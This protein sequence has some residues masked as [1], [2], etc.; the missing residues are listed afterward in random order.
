MSDRH[1]IITAHHQDEA[2][3]LR[4]LLAQVALPPAG[5]QDRA[6]QLIQ[7]ARNRP[8]A[9]FD[10]FLQEFSLSNAEGVSLMV[11]AESLLRIPD[12]ATIDALIEDRLG[13]GDWH[14]HL[15]HSPSRLVN[16]AAWGLATGADLLHHAG[17][18]ARL[19]E[20]VLRAALAQAVRL[21]ARQFVMGGTI[22][23][24]LAR[25]DPSYR[26]SFDMLGE[27]ARTQADADR[28]FDAYAE[29]IAAIGRTSG[30]QGPIVGPGISV[31]LSALHPRF[32]AAQ[33]ERVLAQ[34]V[35]R[36]AELGRLAHGVNV[37]LTIDAEE[38][39]RLHP[40]LDVLERLEW[41]D[42]LGLAV[43][44]YQ[45]RARAV[46]GYLADMARGRGVRLVVRLVKGA[47]WD[48][49]IKRAQEAGLDTYPVFTDKAA[50]DLSYLACARILFDAETFIYP[51]FATHNALTIATIEALAG[52]RTDWEF[53]R[54]HG[55]GERIYEQ[56]APSQPCRVYAPVGLHH[57]LL[58]YLV[59]RL[60]ENGANGSFVN[61]VV[62][63][64]AP[65]DS[66]IQAPHQACGGGL[67]EPSVM[68][69]PERRAAAGWDL[70]EPDIRA[71][72]E[73]HAASRPDHPSPPTSAPTDVNHAVDA[74]AA[75]SGSWD[76]LGGEGRAELLEKASDLV[77]AAAPDL[78]AGLVHEAGKTIPDAIAE[79]RETVDFLRYYAVQARKHFGGDMVLPG[80]TGESNRLR[81]K[82]RGVFAAISP[83]N[84]PLAIFVGQVAAAL[85][86]GN[87]VVAK[88]AP[89]TPRIAARAVDLLH[90]AGVPRDALHLVTGGVEIGQALIDHP[91]VAGVSFTGSTATA[92]AIN[93][94]LA[95]R[96]GPIIPLIAETG[97]I[98]AAIADSSALPE[99]LADDVIVSAFRSAGQRCSSARI[100]FVQNETAKTVERLLAGAAAELRLGPPWQLATDIGP[101]I[102][103]AARDRLQAHADWIG[104]RATRLFEC[105]IPDGLAELTMFGPRAFRLENADLLGAEVFGPILHVVHFARSHLGSVLDW[106]NASGYG[107]TL[108]IHSRIDSFWQQVAQNVR[109]GN[110]YVNRGQ[111]GAVVGVQPFGGEGL[112]GTGPK[113]GGPHTLF[114]YA[115]ETTTSINLAAIGG[116]VGLLTGG[117]QPTFTP[118]GRS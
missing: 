20:P 80:P 16:V 82:G 61:G 113:A 77:E 107:L 13:H 39:S 4:E 114:R 18:A 1:P 5:V 97:G 21:L 101:V 96:A 51:A 46:C 10:A 36:L 106:I 110:I 42:G 92:Q 27:G 54:L 41:W 58:P 109:V 117:R 85:A 12:G 83:W 62:D 81:L 15:G 116:D 70:S 55:M 79:L 23:D 65:I 100:L 115:M 44:A 57:D 47:Y 37:G 45:K 68:F 29:A 34:L 59:R 89:Q 67:P 102:A 35:P 19:G 53:Q 87:A 26:Y 104:H 93:R 22:E 9:L 8:P 73:G 78:I 30:G 94:R 52:P 17:L 75:A 43:Q 112:S 111:I 63:K 69:A 48:G 32:E 25:A 6:A 66:L 56:I 2:A 11:I 76:R 7:A 88:A 3:C 99:Q 24:A 31:K 108:G 28:H 71:M 105:P 50:T 84:F 38:A 86:A 49:E 103:A 91:G 60:L 72:M 95:A 33:T 40:T 14:R 64:N 90:Q 74:A 118:S 98:N